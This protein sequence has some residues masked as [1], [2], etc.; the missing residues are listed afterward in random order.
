MKADQLFKAVPPLDF[1][2][3]AG[4]RHSCLPFRRNRIDWLI[5]AHAASAGLMLVTNNEADF[6]NVPGL[7]V[8]NW[9]L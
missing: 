5:A 8:E 6:D 3:A 9:T 7:E 1:D 4:L 2:E